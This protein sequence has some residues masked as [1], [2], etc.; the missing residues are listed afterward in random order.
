MFLP[1]QDGKKQT[2]GWSGLAPGN[3]VECV[4]WALET[5]PLPP[6]PLNHRIPTSYLLSQGCLLHPGPPDM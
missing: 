5:L 6:V 3:T 1:T 4:K 2:P